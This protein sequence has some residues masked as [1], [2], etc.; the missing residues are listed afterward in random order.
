MFNAS[1]PQ[2]SHKVVAMMVDDALKMDLTS[3]HQILTA[4]P[5]MRTEGL[6]GQNMLPRL[7]L[8]WRH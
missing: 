8:D 7:Q 4:E 5:K 3:D 6:T 1:L 2:S